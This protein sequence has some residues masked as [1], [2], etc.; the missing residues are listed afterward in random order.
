MLINHAS[1]DERVHD[2]PGLKLYGIESYIAVPLLRRNGTYFGTLCA[3]DPAPASLDESSFT[4]FHLLSQLIAFELEAEDEKKQREDEIG[5]LNDVISIAAH[6][7]RQPLTALQ[8]RAQLTLRQARQEGISPR[9][10]ANL[11]E[12]VSAVRRTI[13]L[14]DRLLDV[15]RINV[16]N[17]KLELAE[18]DLIDLIESIRADITAAAPAYNIGLE[19][20]VSLLLLADS[21]RLN[22]VIRNLL[23][24]AV[25]YSPYSQ[26]PILLRVTTRPDRQGKTEAL[27]QVQDHGI[28]VNENDLTHLFERQYRTR[29]ALEAGISGSG[30]GL[31]ISWQIVEAHG[32]QIWAE[33]V[34]TGGLSVNFTVPLISKV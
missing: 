33:S 2:H 23:D 10:S 34:P 13:S 12:Q 8:L 24:N 5:A 31:Y 29:E 1:L 30:F 20:P 22:Q 4:I 27:I 15:G 28:G 21:V 32:G 26:E 19:T 14:T 11:E 25:K 7:L 18:F 16:G 3:L 9:L 6:D 17:F